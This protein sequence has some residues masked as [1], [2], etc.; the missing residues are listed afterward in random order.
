M[1]GD[2]DEEALDPRNFLNGMYSNDNFLKLKSQLENEIIEQ[3]KQEVERKH[4]IKD[5]DSYIADL[6]RWR[7]ERKVRDDQRNQKRLKEKEEEQEKFQE[8]IRKM[9]DYNNG[10]DDGADEEEDI[11]NTDIDPEL[12]KA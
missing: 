9:E 1:G 3:T 5:A 12:K 10:I 11:L 6:N 8:E 4:M 2:H 7:E